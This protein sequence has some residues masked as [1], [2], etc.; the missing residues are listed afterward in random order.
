MPTDLSRFIPRVTRVV[1]PGGIRGTVE[2][3]LPLFTRTGRPPRFPVLIKRDDGIVR[4][5][6]P[7]ELTV[8]AVE[9]PKG[10]PYP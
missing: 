1:T 5:Y 6:A 4:A 8:L 7:D 2:Q 3:V 9:A 10:M